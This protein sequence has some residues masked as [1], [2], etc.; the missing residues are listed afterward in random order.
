MELIW[1]LQ[2][3]LTFQSFPYQIQVFSVSSFK[4]LLASLILQNLYWTE[5]FTKV[6]QSSQKLYKT[7]TK[8]DHCQNV[9][10]LT[11]KHKH[12]FLHKHYFQYCELPYSFKLVKDI[13]I[14]I[15]TAMTF[16]FLQTGK[17]IWKK[18]IFLNKELHF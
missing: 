14:V 16:I 12:Y 17:S 1:R 18:I 5:L 2:I 13:F 8:T 9:N 3:F 4:F 11:P 10:P 6:F 7:Y 15:F